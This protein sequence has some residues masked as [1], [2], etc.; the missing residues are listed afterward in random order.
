M[1]GPEKPPVKILSE[2][3]RLDDQQMA[4]FRVNLRKLFEHLS[5]E[6]IP[7]VEAQLK[8]K[9]EEIVAK[10]DAEDAA[11]KPKIIPFRERARVELP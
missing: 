7:A 10:C 11:R 8:K 4:E 9:F 3:K 5:A 2:R 1:M 6:E